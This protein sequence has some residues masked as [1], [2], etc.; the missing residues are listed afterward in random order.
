MSHTASIRERT[1]AQNSLV[2]LLQALEGMETT[3]EL[4]DESSVKGKITDVDGF[5][6]ICMSDVVFTDRHGKVSKLSNFSVQGR[7]IRFVQVPDEVN[8]I[9]AI[10]K[11][12]ASMKGA[13][14]MGMQWKKKKETVSWDDLK[15]ARAKKVTIENRAKWSVET[16]ET[17]HA[18]MSELQVVTQTGSVEVEQ[19]KDCT[20]NLPITQV[21]QSINKSDIGNFTGSTE[22]PST[23]VTKWFSETSGE[24]TSNVAIVKENY[25]NDVS[26]DFANLQVDPGTG[27]LNKS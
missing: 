17:T 22:L 9:E 7:N 16:Q 4:R 5:M 8:M 18:S 14:T 24:D 11:Q 15:A 13:R 10:Q 27:E 25:T 21:G 3:V 12:L 26:Q 23:S 19:V 1:K 20:T 6:A 2:C